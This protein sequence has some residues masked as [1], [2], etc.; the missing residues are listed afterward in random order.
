MEKAMAEEGLSQSAMARKLGV[1]KAALGKW[2]SGKTKPGYDSLR[3]IA[4]KLGIDGNDL[5]DLETAKGGT[6]VDEVLL[7]KI[8]AMSTEEQDALAGFIEWF[9]GFYSNATKGGAAD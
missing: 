6:A 2:I 5:L 1:D 9:D 8:A 7:E 4:A 3:L